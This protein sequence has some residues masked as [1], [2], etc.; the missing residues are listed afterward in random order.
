MKTREE[1]LWEYIDGTL[2]AAEE[3]RIAQLIADD[4]QWEQAYADQLGFSRSLQDM[5]LDE[6]S[7]GFNFRVMEAIRSETV[8]DPLKTRINPWIIRGI[9]LFFLV[10][11]IVV[12]GVA[13]GKINW[14]GFSA[15][16]SSAVPVAKM[17]SVLGDR[18]AMQVAMF[19][20][21]IMLL[22]LGDRILNRRL[23][24]KISAS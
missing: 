21:V 13:A 12:F 5:E 15:E 11:M 14:S 7:M 16:T 20:G 8:L 2:P 18:S 4:V 17:K 23:H 9:G 22:F 3:K 24:E 6:P 1:Q 10:S 19:A